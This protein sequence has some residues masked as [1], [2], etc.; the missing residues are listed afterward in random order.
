MPRLRHIA[1]AAEDP[2]ATAKFYRDAFDF[3]E[4]KRYDTPLAY[5]VSLTDG[6]I[7]LTVARFRGVDQL[8]KGLDYFGIH[9]MGFLVDDV[10]L[11]GKKL[12]AAGAECFLR[13][14]EGKDHGFEVK[15][16]GPDG[17]VIDISDH[18]W[19]GSAPLHQAD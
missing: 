15:F 7:N 6:V 16:H 12:E 18:P 19:P 17:V 5:A 10:D 1:L 8:G 11:W 2:D 14:E 4:L 13:P 3:K 9:H